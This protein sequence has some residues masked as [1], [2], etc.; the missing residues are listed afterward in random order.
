MLEFLTFSVLNGVQYGLLLFLLAS[1]LTLIF[2]M[3]GVLNF[4]HA[5]FYML[6]AYFG[7]QASLSLGFWPALVVAPLAVGVLGALVERFGLRRVHRLGHVAEL[8]FTFGLAF[9]IDE[10]VVMLWGRTPVD[11]RVPALLDGPA[12][13]LWQTSY[14]AY[15]LFLLLA[16]VAIFA[17]LLMFLTRSRVGL[18]IQASL[19]HPQM[20]SMLGHNVPR[21]FMVMFG[22]GT[23]LAGLAGAIAGPA[24]VTQPSMA[25]L[26]GPILFVIIVLGGLGSL[27]GALIASLAVGLIQTFAVAGEV[28]IA[29]LLARVGVTLGHSE[30][31]GNLWHATLAQLAPV[32]PYLLLVLMLLL[33]PAGLMGARET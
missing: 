6:G 5:S 27:T 8:L 30:W 17:G 2:S 13:M 19:T 1:G 14:P 28:S 4:A 7:F 26:L 33:R 11:Y 29:D 9:V 31:F 18:I 12:F 16:S 10:V 23:G 20:V 32:I 21:I 3:M 22:A 24:L 15:K 25:A